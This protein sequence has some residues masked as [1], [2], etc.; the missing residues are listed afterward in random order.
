MDRRLMLPAKYVQ[1]RVLVCAGC[2]KKHVFRYASLKL[3]GEK[4]Y[5]VYIG[6]PCYTEY[7][8]EIE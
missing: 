4:R 2:G 7:L 6:V 5:A 8:E 1:Q 3:D